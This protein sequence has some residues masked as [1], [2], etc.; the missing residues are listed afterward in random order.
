MQDGLV[1]S[2]GRCTN[3]ANRLV[4]AILRSSGMSVCVPGRGL[5]RSVLAEPEKQV[6]N[7]FE[8]LD[9]EAALLAAGERASISWPTP[10]M[11]PPL[12][13]CRTLTI[14][15][16]SSSGFSPKEAAILDPQHRKF[17]ETAWEAMENAGH[18]P[19]SMNGPIGV[20]AGCGMGSYFYFNICSNPDPGR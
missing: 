13:G 1:R 14:L 5:C 6:S 8:V 9:R 17:L 20:Y 12:P 15:M 16:P 2:G 10:T 3:D 11:C 4:L 19:E 7:R 18:P